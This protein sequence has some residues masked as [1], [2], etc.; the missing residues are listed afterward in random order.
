MANAER[1]RIFV[2]A[3]ARLI[4]DGR[5]IG[6][7]DNVSVSRRY[8]KERIEVLD[9]VELEEQATTGYSVDVNFGVVGIVDKSLV[10]MGLLP[11]AG[12]DN[13]EHLENMIALPPMTVQIEDN[14]TGATQAE[15]QDFEVESESFQV[16]ARGA[17]RHNVSG[18]GRRV[19]D[20]AEV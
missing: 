10:E 6:W 13:E 14:I 4:I 18:V 15:I 8:Q 19:L 12:Q 7:A 9:N 2:G 16:G 17:L 3:R 20:S 1:K 5:R 11:A